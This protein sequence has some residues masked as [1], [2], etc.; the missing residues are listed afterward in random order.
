MDVKT[1]GQEEHEQ[2]QEGNKEGGEE[3]PPLPNNGMP[4][5]WF[6]PP[7]INTTKSPDKQEDQFLFTPII[8]PSVNSADD[9][10]VKVI[11][12]DEI[13]SYLKTTLIDLYP[14]NTNEGFYPLLPTLKLVGIYSLNEGKK[15]D[16]LIPLP[17]IQV[18]DE[19]AAIE[20]QRLRKKTM[21]KQMRREEEEKERKEKENKMRLR[22]I[23]GI[24]SI[25][26]YL[27]K[28]S[29]STS[30]PIFNFILNVIP[31]DYLP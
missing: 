8:P 14:T 31:L 12:P 9:F 6:A 23:P 13:L 5:N 26:K 29:F 17:N 4:F 11:T 15:F 19:R 28:V 10:L 16:D 1:M 3:Q 21:S 20:S 2:Q 22:L 25:G 18:G 24:Q 27:L 7:K 30:L